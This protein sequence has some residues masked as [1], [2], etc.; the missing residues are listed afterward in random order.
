MQTL[1]GARLAQHAESTA[2]APAVALPGREIGYAELAAQVR[3]CA[4]WLARQGCVPGHI[5][6]ITVADEMLHLVTSLALLSLGVPQVCLPTH[7]PASKRESLAEKLQV[8]R[9]VVTNLAHALPGRDVSP[10]TA[11]RHHPRTFSGTLEAMLSDADAPAI[12]CT[13]SGTTGEPKLYSH[14]QRTLAW[15]AERLAE[16]EQIGPGYRALALASL[17]Y[18]VA[19]RRHHTTAYLGFTSV[20]AGNSASPAS[21][22]E[23]CA[24]LRVTSL[25]LSVLQVASLVQD[26]DCRPLPAHT[27]VW[28]LGSA[29][30]VSLR[31]QFKRRFGKTLFVNYGAGEFGRIASTYPASVDDDLEAVGIPAPWIELEIVDA[32][33]NIVPAGEIGEV[34][35]RSGCME[36][37][38]YH[39]PAATARHFKDGWF[40]PRDLASCTPGGSVRLHGRSDDMMNLH[41][42]KIFPAQIERALEALP[43]VRAAAAFARPSA[44]HGDIPVVA[45]ELHEAALATE[46]ELMARAR[47][48]LGVCA[49]RKI[50]LV[51]ALPRNAA[52]KVVKRELADL[53]SSK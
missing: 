36:H 4:A 43:A 19:K 46:E 37:Q 27:I 10:L 29:T 40:Y 32:D 44:I 28:A 23:L 26:A 35:V 15:R 33:D 22:P 6:G 25:E 52:G 9:V 45:V 34:R 39:D 48:L 21:V 50:I 20:F 7:E 30:P 3:D 41:G 18:G 17:E 31:Q 8:K 11:P 16:G 13:S 53:L 51:D 14:S 12:Y 49:P 47:E 5:V 1:F 38:Y 2:R 42:I 24:E